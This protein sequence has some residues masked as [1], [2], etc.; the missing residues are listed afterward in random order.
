MLSRG[1]TKWTII[2]GLTS[3]RRI[4]SSDVRFMSSAISS[5][6]FCRLT[7]NVS[8]LP[9]SFELKT[10]PKP[11]SANFS[12][13]DRSLMSIVKSLKTRQTLSGGFMLPLKFAHCSPFV[14][15][16]YACRE[17]VT[18]VGKQTVYWCARGTICRG[19]AG[20]RADGEIWRFRYSTVSQRSIVFTRRSGQER[21]ELRH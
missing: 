9:L 16:A 8:G 6:T 18:N 7:A 3:F 10:S 19:G 15:A 20:S 5:G 2:N 14:E 12:P 1:V 21:P 13:K 4:D 11:P 17:A